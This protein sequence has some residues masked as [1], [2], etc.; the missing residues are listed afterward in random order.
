MF[1]FKL[2]RNTKYFLVWKKCNYINKSV[3]TL[4]TDNGR[5]VTRGND[6]LNVHSNK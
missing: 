3:Q 4:V 5:A 6:V 1:D 2:N